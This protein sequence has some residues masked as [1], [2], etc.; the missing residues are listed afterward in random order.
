M[1]RS[2]ILSITAH[3][4]CPLMAFANETG[5]RSTIPLFS[6]LTHAQAQIDTGYQKDQRS[7]HLDP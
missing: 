1:Q 4:A 7:Y 6:V 5:Y 2:L 3:F